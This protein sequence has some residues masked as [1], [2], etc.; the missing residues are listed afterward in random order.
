MHLLKAVVKAAFELGKTIARVHQV[1]WC[2]FTYQTAA[3]LVEAALE[4]GAKAR[5]D[6]RGG[7][8]GRPTSCSARSSMRCC[9]RWA[10]SATCSAG[11]SI[12]ARQLASALWREAVLAIRF[13][14]KSVA[15]MLDWAAAQTAGVLRPHRPALRG[16]RRRDHRGHRLGHRARRRTCSTCWAAC[17]SASAIR[18]SYALNYLDKDFIPGIAKFVKGALAAASSWPS[19]S[20][21]TVGKVFEVT[22]EVVRGALRGRRHADGALRRDLKHPDQ[23]MDNLVRAA[24]QLGQTL[25]E[26]GRC[27]PAT[28]A[29]SS[30]TSSCGRWSRSARTSRTCWSRCS[31]SRSAARHGHLPC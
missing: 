20:S 31:R 6:P 3:R 16:R 23:A 27:L 25:N 22:L 29:R 7:R 13:V 8:R 5:G 26:R 2:E 10:R 1:R 9:R 18:S 21:W 14:K 19:W 15:E 30:S 17:G 12:A 24:R 11:C 4:V 28:P